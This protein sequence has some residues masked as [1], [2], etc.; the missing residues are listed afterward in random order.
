[1]HGQPRL[2]ETKR[3]QRGDADT[4][5]NGIHLLETELLNF[6]QGLTKQCTSTAIIKSDTPTSRAA[7]WILRPAG[8]KGGS[9]NKPA[10]PAIL[11]SVLTEGAC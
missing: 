4:F 10:K 9:K 8:K 1:M 3:I 6:R 5:A 2:L 7:Q 11:I